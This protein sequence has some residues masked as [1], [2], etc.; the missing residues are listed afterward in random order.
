MCLGTSRPHSRRQ[1]HHW[2]RW[3]ASRGPWPETSPWRSSTARG[4]Q[5]PPWRTSRLW[6]GF[7][8]AGWRRRIPGSSRCRPGR[9]ARA[10]AGRTSSR[11]AGRGSRCKCPIRS[12]SRAGRSPTTV[13]RSGTRPGS[14]QRGAAGRGTPGRSRTASTG[15]RRG[16]RS[17]SRLP[18]SARPSRSTPRS[19]RSRRRPPPPRRRPGKDAIAAAGGAGTLSRTTR[20]ARRVLVLPPQA[21][22]AAP[23]AA[24]LRMGPANNGGLRAGSAVRVQGLE[25]VELNGRQAMLGDFDALRGRW[26]ARFLKKPGEGGERNRQP[27]F[28]KCCVSLPASGAPFKTSNEH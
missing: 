3:S 15:A 7:S 17:T 22:S 12:C 23:P 14:W 21:G 28:S 26:T 20:G 2:P 5:P 18:S 19:A 24:G 6:S 27:G 10:G 9:T 11:A 16:A 13:P 8:A 25:R 4:G 1:R